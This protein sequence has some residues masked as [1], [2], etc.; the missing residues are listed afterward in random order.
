MALFAAMVMFLAVVGAVVFVIVSDNKKEIAMKQMTDYKGKKSIDDNSTRVYDGIPIA[1]C[2]L[3]GGRGVVVHK[4][5]S[6]DIFFNAR[7]R[8]CGRTL[9]K[10]DGGPDL[11]YVLTEWN[12]WNTIKDDVRPYCYDFTDDKGKGRNSFNDFKSKLNPP[13]KLRS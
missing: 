1:K 8:D 11:G 10:D 12:N 7:C 5:K 13:V 3:C 4:I 2:H 6:K 9:F